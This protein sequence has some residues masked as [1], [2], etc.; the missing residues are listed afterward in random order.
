MNI[1]RF[2]LRKAF[3]ACSLPTLLAACSHLGTNSFPVEGDVEL[4]PANATHYGSKIDY[5]DRKR[6][7]TALEHNESGN[8]EK[9]MNQ[10]SYIHYK[11]MP[12]KTYEFTSKQPCRD[13]IL[14]I[15]VDD[16]VDQGRGQACRQET[17]DW[18]IMEF[19]NGY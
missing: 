5:R 6:I 12:T 19:D 3:L 7:F 18:T 11:F 10:Y 13:F 15:W 2:K 8:A 4:G 1:S 14:E 16:H 9:W 17:G